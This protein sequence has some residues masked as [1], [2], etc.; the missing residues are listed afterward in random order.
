MDSLH[1]EAMVGNLA[2][3]GTVPVKSRLLVL[4]AP[5][6][7]LEIDPDQ[8]DRQDM[9]GERALHRL[10]TDQTQRVHNIRRCE[11]EQREAVLVCPVAGRSRAKGMAEGWIVLDNTSKRES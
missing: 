9:T 8:K 3:T 7:C 2:S 5:G 6:V 10:A 11:R 4:P 1:Q